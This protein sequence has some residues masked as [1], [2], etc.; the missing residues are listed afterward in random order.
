MPKHIKRKAKDAAVN[1]SARIPGWIIVAIVV[2][3]TTH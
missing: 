1:I 3:V 2:I